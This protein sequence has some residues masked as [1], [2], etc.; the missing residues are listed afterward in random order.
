MATLLEEPLLTETLQ[1]LPGWHTDGSEISREIHLPTQADAQLRHDVDITAASM[2]HAP[3]VESV[4]GGT[5]FA[6][7]TPEVGGV[8]ELDIAMAAHISDLAHR[9]DH[10]VPGVHAQRRDE[11]EITDVALVVGADDPKALLGRR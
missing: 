9:L 8:S 1:A 7:S 6:L 4:S 10:N 5:R 3:H 2:G 11:I